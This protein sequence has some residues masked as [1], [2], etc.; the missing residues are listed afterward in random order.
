MD[1]LLEATREVFLA[2]G[3]RGTTIDD[4]AGA[5]GVSRGSFYTYFPSKRDALLAVGADAS[6]VFEILL[7]ELR[8]L[9]WDDRVPAMAAWVESYFRFLDEYGS[10]VLTWTEAAYTDDDLRA[11]GMQW[12]LTSCRRLGETLEALRGRRFGSCTQQG[13]VVSSMLERAW[14]YR[15]L[16]GE[17][18][19]DA[20]LAIS[21]AC[22]IAATLTDSYDRT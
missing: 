9:P 14:S 18:V 16:Y 5:A 13:L 10:F 22:V 3:Y 12:H 11:A 7:E 2:Y 6:A 20:E 8:S 4:I 15:R 19:D 1:D 21:A 17:A